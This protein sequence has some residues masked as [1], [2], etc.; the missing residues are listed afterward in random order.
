MA[1]DSHPLLAREGWIHIA[2]AVA[3]AAG[4]SLWIGGIPALVLWLVAGFVVQFFRDPRRQVPAGQHLAV[5]PA[6]GKVVFAGPVQ[7]PYLDRSAFKVSIFMDV[8]SVHAN[9]IPVAGLVRE[10]WYERGKFLN[11][12]LDK[13][14]EQNER[15]ALWLH[16]ESQGD[17][18]CVQVAGLIA[19]RI[20]CHVRPGDRVQRGQR[21]GFIR[22]GSRV[23]V[24]LPMGF[25]PRVEI[26]DRVHAGS[27]VLGSFRDNG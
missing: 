7:D 8:F 6:D 25:T 13:A 5:C 4:V 21:Y 17:I 23:D 15:N 20:L 9:R 2:L 1:A 19:R 11:A 18:I 10:V 16:S 12:A 27:K 26:G 3:A 14:S 24:Y 22:F